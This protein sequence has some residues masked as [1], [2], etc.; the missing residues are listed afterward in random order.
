MGQIGGLGD[1]LD[2]STVQGQNAIDQ[3]RK[4]IG[5][6]QI[7]S[8][9]ALMNTIRQGLQGTGV[10][11]GNTNALDSSAA[12]A[13]ARAY[14]RYGNVQ[15]NSINNTASVGN[16][17]QD[18]AQSS[19]NTATSNGLDYIAKQRDAAIA[20]IQ[21]Q[22]STAL[23]SLATTVAYLGGDASQIDVKGIQA[24]IIQNAQD[25]LAQVDQ[26]IQSMIGA[27]HAATPDQTAQAAEA[28]QNAGV[29]PSGSTPYQ[30]ASPVATPT[31]A[32]QGAPT[33]LI[34]LALKPKTSTT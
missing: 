33:T 21:A 17:A 24:Q 12:G 23:Q 7:N 20:G 29:V 13:A 10:S 25:Q 6:T 15:T 28:A 34:P 8:I 5:L 32:S 9:K 4:G 16:E 2:T 26:H 18:S 14:S 30:I 22:A 11:L 27:V 3:A 19:L 1:T 31:V